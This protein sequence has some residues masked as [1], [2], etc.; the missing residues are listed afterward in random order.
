MRDPQRARVHPCGRADVKREVSLSRAAIDRAEAVYVAGAKRAY[1]AAWREVQAHLPRTNTQTGGHAGDLNDPLVRSAIADALHA[2]LLA[3][4]RD[5]A[6][7]M[8]STGSWLAKAAGPH[9]GPWEGWTGVGVPPIGQDALYARYAASLDKVGGVKGMSDTALS[10]METAVQ[11]FY[12]DPEMATA[13]LAARLS[14]YFSDWKAVQV[15]ITETTR[16]ATADRTMVANELGVTQGTFHT[17][18]DVLVCSECVA[19]D[20]TTVDI[21]DPDTDPPVHV[22]CRCGIALLLDTGE[23]TGEV[24]EGGE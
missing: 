23:D 19:L 15:A 20:G 8:C 1:S 4:A 14:P 7:E 21:G 5:A 2:G 11:D 10:D 6:R 12:A 17:S 22:N 18:E 13:D 9:A 3:A 24:V 16:M